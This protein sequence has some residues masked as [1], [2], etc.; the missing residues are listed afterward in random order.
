M[1]GAQ[2]R[3]GGETFS[4]KLPQE[5][6]LPPP[7]QNVLHFRICG[8]LFPTTKILDKSL[9]MYVLNFAELSVRVAFRK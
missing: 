4:S 3:G 6:Q 1:C 2:S 8:H 5:N 9:Y 7:L